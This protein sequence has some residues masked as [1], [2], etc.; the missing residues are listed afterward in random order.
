M[1]VYDSHCHLESVLKLEYPESFALIPGV[2]LNDAPD[3]VNIRL[4]YPQ[5]KIG[6]GLHPWY[7]DNLVDVG[8]KLR[9]LVKQYQPDFIG[10]IGLDYLKPNKDLQ[11]FVFKE[12]LKIALEFNLPVIIHCVRAYNDVLMLLKR[13][14][15]N[16]GIIHAFNDRAS[17]AKQFTDLGF[18][19]GIGSLITKESK[20]AKDI[21]NININ[22]IVFESDSP[23]MPTFNKSYSEIKDTFLYAQIAAKKLELNLIDLCLCA[24]NNLKHLFR[25]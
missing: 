21:K 24:N 12:Q 10:E 8:N 2:N 5:Y 13:Q 15:I 11:Q 1:L 9:I 20:I 17:T 18:L 14:K 25:K 22:H 6:F 23:F 16:C 3:L 7:I 19:L 4:K